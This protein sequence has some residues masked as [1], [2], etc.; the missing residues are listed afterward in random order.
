MYAII[1]VGFPIQ[2]FFERCIEHFQVYS[3]LK[4]LLE[5]LE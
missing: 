3:S 2:F 4:A 5:T 1:P